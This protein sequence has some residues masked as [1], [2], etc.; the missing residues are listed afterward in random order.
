MF[1][2]LKELLLE[3][4]LIEHRCFTKNKHLIIQILRGKGETKT[5]RENNIRRHQCFLDVH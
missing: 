4:F 1:G 3:A 5:D 2:N